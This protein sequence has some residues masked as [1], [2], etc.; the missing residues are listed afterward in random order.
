MASVQMPRR[1]G[2]EVP[3]PMLNK[4]ADTA[5]PTAFRSLSHGKLFLPEID[6]AERPVASSSL[7]GRKERRGRRVERYW[8]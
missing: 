1:S 3:E 4:C 8:L 2:Y 7:P 6:H 5:W